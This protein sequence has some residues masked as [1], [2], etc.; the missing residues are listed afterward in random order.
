MVAEKR[1]PVVGLRVVLLCLPDRVVAVPA[2][3]VRRVPVQRG[4]PRAER[5]RIAVPAAFELEALHHDVGAVRVGADGGPCFLNSV[6]GI[7]S[8]S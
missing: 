6:D 7:G 5:G 3:Q 1:D 8:R 2:V 4:E